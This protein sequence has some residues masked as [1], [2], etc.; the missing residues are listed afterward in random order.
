MCLQHVVCEGLGCGVPQTGCDEYSLLDRGALAR[1]AAVAGQGTDTDGLSTQS[2]LI[3]VV[4]PKQTT[5]LDLTSA[6]GALS[7]LASTSSVLLIQSLYKTDPKVIT[8]DILINYSV[9]LLSMTLKE[10]IN[11]CIVNLHIWYLKAKEALRL[12]HMLT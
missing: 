12:E 7:L 3:R 6:S 10:K 8:I 5:E 11:N 2:H 4:N 1:T 9:Q